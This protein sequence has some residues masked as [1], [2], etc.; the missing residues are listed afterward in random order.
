M[1]KLSALLISAFSAL[2]L[3]LPA[4]AEETEDFL[5]AVKSDGTAVIT[6]FI[7][8]E[9]DIV[10]PAQLDGYEVSEIGAY[11]FEHEHSLRTVEIPSSVRT[12]SEKAFSAC[13]GLESVKLSEGLEEIKDYAFSE[14]S[15]LREITIPDSVTSLG[16]S[17]FLNCS[18]LYKAVIGDGVKVISESAFKDCYVLE[19]L[20]LGENV[21]EIE[22]SAFESARIPTIYI[23]LSVQRIHNYAFD[24]TGIRNVYYA[25]TEKQWESI[26]ISYGNS[27]LEYADIRYMVDAEGKTDPAVLRK[28]VGVIVIYAGVVAAIIVV[29]IV[30]ISRTRKKD[31]CPYC[32][33]HID[34]DSEYCGNCGSKL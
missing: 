21:T 22:K 5:Y 14:C 6:E 17:A 32:N 34:E 15:Y 25:G 18:Y 31:E 16:Q 24:E 19:E 29:V 8:Y 1:K 28:T 13:Y 10:I 23:P 30:V 26:G 4:S 3:C 7:G 27:D 33:S 11:C 2:L 20:S 9:T 12:I